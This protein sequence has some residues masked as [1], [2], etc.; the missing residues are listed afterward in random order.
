VRVRCFDAAV[1]SLLLR[2]RLESRQSCAKTTVRPD[3]LVAV[4]SLRRPVPAAEL[5]CVP[6]FC[7]TDSRVYTR[8]RGCRVYR[9]RLRV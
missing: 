2:V 6:Y 4:S 7:F 1:S 3:D 8:M 9:Y 5:L